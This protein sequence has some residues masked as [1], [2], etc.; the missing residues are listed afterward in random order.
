MPDDDDEAK[1]DTEAGLVR[2]AAL[3]GQL[4]D[5]LYPKK[6]NAPY[7]EF[8]GIGLNERLGYASPADLAEQYP[9]F[10]W[11]K[12]EPHARK[13]TGLLG[14]TMEGRHWI[15]HLYVHV[16]AIEH[17]HHRLGLHGQP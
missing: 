8:V 2:A 17:A 6:L 7:R 1:T 15:A 13:A 16:F 9:G 3:I 14:L 5:P 11:F 12:V 10:L 4:G